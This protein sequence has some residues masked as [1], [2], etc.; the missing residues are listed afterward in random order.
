MNMQE[1]DPEHRVLAATLHCTAH[2]YKGRGGGGGLGRHRSQLGEITS[3][4]ALKLQLGQND[5]PSGVWG[6]M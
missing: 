3:L 1:G 4:Q 6:K 5:R 2:T